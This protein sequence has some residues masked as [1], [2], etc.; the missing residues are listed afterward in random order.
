MAAAALALGLATSAFAQ[1]VT[2]AEA[3]PVTSET[4]AHPASTHTAKPA[5]TEKAA[6]KQAPYSGPTLPLLVFPF[7][8]SDVEQGSSVLGPA[9][10]KVVKDATLRST[11]YSGLSFSDRHPAIKR[12]SADGVLKDS[13][14]QPSYGLDG[15]DIQKATKIA[16]VMGVPRFV[17]GAIEDLQI[18]R[19]KRE[20]SVSI[21]ARVVD[22]ATGATVSNFTA[23]GTT[24]TSMTSGT[25]Q[26]LA[27]AAVD[28]A[29]EKLASQIVPPP[30]S[31]PPD[32]NLAQG[33]PLQ[34]ENG[35]AQPTAGNGKKKKNG[36][37]LAAIALVV[38][39]I[40]AASG[41]GGGGGGSSNG[42]GG[43][44]NPPPPPF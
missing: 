30:S 3:P 39:L 16:Q 20:A 28:A 17:V 14:L 36:G 8:S 15:E 19:T 29:A 4:A 35:K 25:D 41:G 13:D 23:A 5:E 9:V 31:S 11:E 10:A 24:P 40:I 1:G 12:A 42:G 21:S 32:E 7:N 27:A 34:P 26:Q 44:D 2:P 22:A 38:G 6:T 43:I 18:D 37:A 33:Q